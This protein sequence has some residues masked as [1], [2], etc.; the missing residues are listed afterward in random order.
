METVI[1][2]AE[3]EKK[4]RD[5]IALHL[6]QEGYKVVP[7]ADGAEALHYWREIK[8]DLLVL[9]LMLPGLSGWEVLKK[10][11]QK[12]DTPVIILTARADEIDKLLGLELGAD[13][14]MTKPFSPRELSAR[15]KAV[16]R[17]SRPQEQSTL[18]SYHDLRLDPERMEAFI[19]DT[20]MQLTASE[21]KILVL[22]AGNP[23]QVFSRL[24]ILERIFGD[25]YEGYERTVVPHIAI[26]A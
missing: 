24:Y 18:V 12:H 4:L 1:L 13:D 26:S 3:D 25:M 14:Y 20:L 7:A 11:R 10:I 15:I 22:L 23:G 5:M 16:L 19:G 6:E 8:P 21:F 2:L 17:R 9:D